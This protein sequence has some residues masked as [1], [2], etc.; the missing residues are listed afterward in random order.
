MPPWPMASLP[1]S[2]R[3]S[4]MISRS[5]LSDGDHGAGARLVLDHHRLAELALE[6]GMDDAR[7]GVRAAARREADDQAD[8]PIRKGA[9]RRDHA[10]CH[11]GG[12]QCRCP[13]DDAARHAFALRGL[14]CIVSHRSQAFH[15]G[16]AIL[17]QCGTASAPG[18]R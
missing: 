7:H 18:R 17:T 16:K 4:A 12:D 11:A 2:R 6:A 8:R 13:S 14:C 15:S 10:R 5:D 1:G 9:R 3:A